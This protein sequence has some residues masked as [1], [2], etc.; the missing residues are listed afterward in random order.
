MLKWA[1]YV[2][3]TYVFQGVEKVVKEGNATSENILP[4]TFNLLIV[5]LLWSSFWCSTII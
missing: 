3:E 5:V 2:Q 4:Q 1:I